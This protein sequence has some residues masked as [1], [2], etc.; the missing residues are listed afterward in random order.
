MECLWCISGLYFIIIT[1]PFHFFGRVPFPK[2]RAEFDSAKHGRIWNPPLQ[3][4]IFSCTGRFYICHGAG[5][6]F[7]P[8]SIFGRVRFPKTRADMESAKHG[9]IWNPQN[10]GGNGFRPYAFFPNVRADSISARCSFSPYPPN[11]ST[12]ISPHISFGKR[13]S[14]VDFKV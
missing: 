11:P 8:F 5:I 13:V 7:N 3:Q 12:L 9:R 10:T 1:I 2:T 14:R 6:I 4:H